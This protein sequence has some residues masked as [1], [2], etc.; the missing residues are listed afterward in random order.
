MLPLE[1]TG[2]TRWGR[3]VYRFTADWEY[4]YSRLGFYLDVRIP[5]FYETDYASIPWPLHY[6]LPPAGPWLRGAVIHDYLC[7]NGTCRFMADAVFRHVMHEDGVRL[8]CVMYYAVRIYWQVLGRWI[9]KLT[10][11]P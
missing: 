7:E 5:R 2:K 4:S 10:R 8:R 3:K 1:D 11:K 9:K 6:I